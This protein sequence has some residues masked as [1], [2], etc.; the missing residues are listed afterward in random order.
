MSVPS[1]VYNSLGLSEII[2]NNKN[3][4]ICKENTPESLAETVVLLLQDKILYKKLS[5]GARKEIAKYNWDN[6]ARAALK[7]ISG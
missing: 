6:T 3:G 4:L 5:D 1:I 2:V 7:V